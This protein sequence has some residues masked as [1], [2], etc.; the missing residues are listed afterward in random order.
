MVTMVKDRIASNGKLKP[1]MEDQGKCVRLTYAN[2]FHLDIVTAVPRVSVSET[3]IYVALNDGKHWYW[4]ENDPK[5]YAVWFGTKTVMLK[6]AHRALARVEP[7]PARRETYEKETLRRAVQ[8]LKRRRDVYY[9]DDSAAP[10]S[11][12]LTT[13]AGELY[14]GEGFC[15]DA[16]LTILTRIAEQMAQSRGIVPVTNPINRQENFTEKWTNEQ[17]DQFKEFIAIFITEMAELKE[18]NGYKQLAKKL[19]EMFDITGHGIVD[20]AMGEYE[21]KL[22]SSREKGTLGITSAAALTTVTP[23]I[24]TPRN[25]FYGEAAK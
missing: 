7:A 18:C 6:S 10:S 4:K 22:S 19:R 24:V 15:Y 1:L 21:R 14:E 16:L 25:N 9:G 23:A 17:Y 2:D 3:S 11:I 5:R 13:I 12:L 8:L 20:T